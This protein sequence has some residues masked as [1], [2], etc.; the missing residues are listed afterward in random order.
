MQHKRPKPHRLRFPL[1]KG[2]EAPIS[3]SASIRA[4][5]LAVSLKASRIGTAMTSTLRDQI[6]RFF[7][8]V[9]EIA[10]KKRLELRRG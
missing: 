6:N 5:A 9:S 4:L 1:E 3:G 10:W 8:P 2:R 7:K